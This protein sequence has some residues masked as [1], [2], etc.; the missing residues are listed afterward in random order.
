MVATM[1]GAA[2]TPVVFLL[3]HCRGLKSLREPPCCIYV[4]LCSMWFSGGKPHVLNRWCNLDFEQHFE[5]PLTA[6]PSK[7][8]DSCADISL[9]GSANMH[10]GIS[11]LRV[12]SV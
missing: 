3:I 7:A 8:E 1:P 9:Q 10:R 11:S 6:T 5:Q 4:Q 2:T 12:P